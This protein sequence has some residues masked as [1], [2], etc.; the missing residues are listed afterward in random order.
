MR[1]KVLKHGVK[2]LTPIK[3][4]T[5]TAH[6]IGRLTNGTVFDASMKRGKPI[7]FPVGIGR[8]VRGWDIALQ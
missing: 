4:D 5:V 2:N 6:Y 1:K 8:V 3:G 7:S